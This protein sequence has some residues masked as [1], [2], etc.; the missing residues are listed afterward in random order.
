MFPS[1]AALCNA[2]RRLAGGG[3][4]TEVIPLPKGGPDCANISNMAYPSI[5]ASHHGAIRKGFNAAKDSS[6]GQIGGLDD[7]Y[8]RPPK[9]MS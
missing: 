7:R 5:S 2:V 8:S 6:E 1:K 9:N 4:K 3:S